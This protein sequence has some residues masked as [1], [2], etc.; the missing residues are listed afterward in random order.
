[1]EPA[2]RRPLK[3]E[4]EQGD[5]FIYRDFFSLSPGISTFTSRPRPRRSTRR[6]RIAAISSVKRPEPA[7]PEGLAKAFPF[8]IGCGGSKEFAA[9]PNVA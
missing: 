9:A 4:H 2:A 8:S 5:R 3:H 7:S 6:A 1:M